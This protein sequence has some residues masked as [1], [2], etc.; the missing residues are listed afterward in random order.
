MDE[1]NNFDK[2]LNF[3]FTKMSE[4]CITFLDMTIFINTSDILE[5]KIYR[6]NGLNT[7]ITNFEQSILSP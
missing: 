2:S 5:L 4:K 7:V 1:I 3:T 6:K